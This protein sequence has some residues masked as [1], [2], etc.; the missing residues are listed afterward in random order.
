M[1]VNTL[2]SSSVNLT[3]T[4]LYFIVEVFRPISDVKKVEMGLNMYPKKTKTRQKTH[5]K[6][7]LL[8]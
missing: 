8:G 4:R 7:L 2:E 3:K 1:F 6:Y 5:T